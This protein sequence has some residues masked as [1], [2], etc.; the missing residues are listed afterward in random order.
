MKPGQYKYIFPVTSLEDC[1]GA[2]NL[3][4]LIPEERAQED[5]GEVEV[6]WKEKEVSPRACITNP[7]PP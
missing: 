6:T 3:R 2:K 7:P 1:L 5:A 4:K